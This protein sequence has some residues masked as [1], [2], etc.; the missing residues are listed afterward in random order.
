V[1]SQALERLMVIAVN[2]ERAAHGLTPYTIDPRLTQVA[3]AH[4]ADMVTRNYF[5]HV[6]PE[7]VTLWDRLER[8][9]LDPYWAGENIQSN[10][11]AGEAA[12]ARAI[13]WFMASTPHRNNILHSHYTHIGVGVVRDETASEY[14]TP[15]TFTLV[16]AELPTSEGD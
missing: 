10:S 9:G 5:A 15:T 4:A 8:A 3:R 14:Y 16:F 1:D 6:T 7:G 11:G 13:A 2:A 12:V